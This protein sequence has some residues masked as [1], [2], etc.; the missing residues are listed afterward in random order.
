MRWAQR[1]RLA[2]ILDQLRDKGAVNRRDLME[3]FGISAPQAATDFRHFNETHPSA[4][5][6]DTTRKAYVAYRM[7]GGTGRN[8][9]DAAN[10]LMR[11]HNDELELI[12]RCDPDMVRDVAAAL[13]YERGR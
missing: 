9:T 10:S 2:F 7:L 6:Y 3:K 1:Q 11:A 4:M 5:K 13:I 8:T 12:V